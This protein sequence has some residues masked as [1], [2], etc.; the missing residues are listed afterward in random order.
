MINPLPKW[1][2]LHY[3]RLWNKFKDKKFLFLQAEKLLKVE[4]VSII[5]SE[6]KKSGWLFISFNQK[7]SRKRLYKLIDPIIAIKEMTKK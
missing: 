5:L 2:M 7:D 3:S 6:L 1:I 4:N